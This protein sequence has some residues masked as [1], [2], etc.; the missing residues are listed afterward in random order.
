MRAGAFF[1]FL[2]LVTFFFVLGCIE[3][4]TAEEWYEKGLVLN[5]MGKYE[6]ALEAFDNAIQID[7]DH[8]DAKAGELISL[9]HLSRWNEAIYVALDGLDKIIQKYPGAQGWA[10]KSIFLLYSERYDE[11]LEAI[12][13]ALQ[14]EPENSAFWSLKGA[15]LNYL[16]KSEEALELHEKALQKNP[17]EASSWDFYAITLNDLGRHEDALKA[18]YKAIELHPD[19]EEFWVNLGYTLNKLEKNTEAK[20][21]FEKSIQLNPK[22]G[23]GWARLGAALKQLGR[24][25]DAEYAFSKAEDLGVWDKNSSIKR[26]LH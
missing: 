3:S 11:G 13:N 8:L 10:M 14:Y 12:N 24:D 4:K 18:N 20:E 17:D 2:T 5:E 22:Y 1:L 26:M 25:R 21:A 16:G 6:E 23:L 7:P 15:F 19:E 9:A